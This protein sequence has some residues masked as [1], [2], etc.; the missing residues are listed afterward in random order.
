[1]EAASAPQWDQDDQ[2][3]TEPWLPQGGE[4]R[5]PPLD[6]SLRAPRVPRE[7]VDTERDV[8]AYSDPPRPRDTQSGI[9]NIAPEPPRR[10]QRFRGR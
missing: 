7:L 4:Q 2:R 10:A 5:A 9:R 3:P 6:V 1:M 8:A